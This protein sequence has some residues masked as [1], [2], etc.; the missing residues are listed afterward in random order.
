MLSR[1]ELETIREQVEV[2]SDN[3]IDLLEVAHMLLWHIDAMEAHDAPTKLPR[4]ARA[5]P[6]GSIRL[7]APRRYQS[8]RKA[9]QDAYDSV[10][11]VRRRKAMQEAVEKR[12]GA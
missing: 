10:G 7:G 1:D 3:P 4:G 8:N 5:L 11:E 9:A 12:K 6:D 2:G